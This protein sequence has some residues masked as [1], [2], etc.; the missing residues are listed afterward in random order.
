MRTWEGKLVRLRAMASDDVGPFESYARG[1]AEEAIFPDHRRRGYASDAIT[2]LIRAF[3]EEF[4]YQKVNVRIHEFNTA[5]ITLHEQLG[6]Q[7]D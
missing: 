2:A 1:H 5:S 6:F 7:L 3:F 4:R